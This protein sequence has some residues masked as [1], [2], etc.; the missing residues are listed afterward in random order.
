ML[1]S[2]QIID[3]PH[4][5]NYPHVYPNL[6]SPIMADVLGCQ[7][8]IPVGRSAAYRAAL[9]AGIAAGLYPSE[10]DELAQIT[11]IERRYD[12]DRTTQ[13]LYFENYE[14]IRELNR[15]MR[16]TT[17]LLDSLVNQVNP[18]WV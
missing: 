17:N 14:I 9:L 1:V 16:Q 8:L 2:D 12:P 18:E 11:T 4:S 13:S 15:S 10:G 5:N 6:C 7:L 3:D